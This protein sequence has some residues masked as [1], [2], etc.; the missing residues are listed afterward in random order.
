MKKRN[1]KSI[2]AMLLVLTMLFSMVTLV[3]AEG[4]EV[5]TTTP[6]GETE[7]TDG[8]YDDG[9][10][11]GYDDGYSDGFSDGYGSGWSD[12]YYNGVEDNKDIFTIIR[13][14]IEEIRY[15][16]QDFFKELRRK[17]LAAFG[18]SDIDKNYLPA[19]DSEN[20][21]EDTEAYYLC[22]EFNEKMDALK[23]P[24]KP[25]SY[26][27]TAKVGIDIVDCTG[28]KLVAGIVNPVVE[29]YLVDDVTEYEYEQYYAPGMQAV[30]VTPEG[31]KSATKT[32]NEDGTTDY[33]F[34]LIEE[35]T[36]FDGE[37]DYL[38]DSNGELSYG[39][40]YNYDVADVLLM[41]YFDADPVK[42]KRATIRYPGTTVKA[43]ADAE[44]RI[45]ALD[46]L[47][48][49]EG[50]GKASA[51]LLNLKVEAK[52]YRNEGF[53]IT[54]PDFDFDIDTDLIPDESQD[55]LEDDA[56]AAA[57]IE[58]FQGIVNDTAAAIPDD[59]T[60]T[61]TRD[62]Q[63]QITDCPGGNTVASILA[64]IVDNFTGETTDTETL[65]EGE[66]SYLLDTISLYPAGLITAEKTANEDGTTDYSFVLASEQAVFDGVRT[67]G[68]KY[69]DGELV[70]SALQH[71]YICMGVIPETLDLGPV[72]INN[73]D[74]YYHGATITAK[75]D[76]EGRL[77]SY[78]V[79]STVEGTGTGKVGPISATIGLAGNDT[80]TIEIIYS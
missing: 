19:A 51:Y 47:M 36:F 74:I 18:L 7:T 34:E 14:R 15:N 57:I 67:Y 48:P 40:F 30:Y 56:E 2:A 9:Y 63:V 35:A 21:G 22:E 17:F 44:G 32:V 62:L 70:E 29:S 5:P 79:T 23:Y 58:E 53:T 39:N 12:G 77:V 55:T 26:V 60:L 4:T 45:T 37:D 13:E 64:P 43:T 73:A 27:K 8:S 68:V 59:A 61:R 25:I 54:Y 16:I 3:S 38:L 28:G 76:A 33:E 65:K 72:T 41:S 11:D 75:V 10:N 31:L 80:E 1:F 52:G 66:T 46:I 71:H 24:M 49:V 78:N 20:L 50:S 6:S 42:I 69:A